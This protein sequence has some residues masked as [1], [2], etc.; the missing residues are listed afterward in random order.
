MP[1]S[2]RLKQLINQAQFDEALHLLIELSHPDWPEPLRFVNSR[3]DIV[4]N[5]VTYTACAFLIPLP[6]QS[7]SELPDSSLRIS[8]VDRFII[9][10]LREITNR[11]HGSIKFSVISSG[12]LDYIEK[13]PHE[14]A[15]KNPAAVAKEVVFQVGK[16]AS[17]SENYPVHRR[18]PGTHPGLFSNAV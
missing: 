6:V 3:K 5:G 9:R 4:S 1:L 10:K 7:Q 2:N 11:S 17:L 14:L 13:G 12:D 15:W 16:S 18:R 8:N